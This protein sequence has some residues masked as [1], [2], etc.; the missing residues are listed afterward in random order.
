MSLSTSG[1]QKVFERITNLAYIYEVRKSS[2]FRTRTLHEAHQ[3][4]SILRL[5]P[6]SLSFRDIRAIKD[7]YGHGTTCVK[8]DMYVVAAGS[9]FSL[10]DVVDKEHHST[11]RKRLA[12]AFSA[13]NLEGWEY[14]VVDKCTRLVRQ[15]DLL[16]CQSSKDT[17]PEGAT[18]DWRLWSNLFTV[19][20]IADIALSQHLGLL[21]AGKDTVIA[22]DATGNTRQVGFIRSL[23]GIGRVAAPIVWSTKWY[24][25]LK[26]ILS[27]FKTFR[28]ELINYVAYDDIVR[29]LVS[30]R[31]SRYQKGEKLDDFFACLLEDRN[32]SPVGLA[33]GEIQAEV[34]VFMN[35]GSDT[36]AVALTHVLYY[37][38]KNPDKLDRLRRELDMV[39]DTATVVPTYTSVRNIAY[40]RA[41]L[42]EALRLSPPVSFGL[43]RK[44][45]AGGASINDFTMQKGTQA[46]QVAAGSG[47]RGPRRKTGW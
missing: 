1:I 28:T 25:F 39:L 45:L 34:N 30:R 16:C 17:G 10:L 38:L 4:N 2:G 15:F 26:K 40:L 22:Q 19:E 11:K 9:H 5:G 32:G 21:E 29:H 41:C 18:V 47:K 8:G 6:D 7:I 13:K 36:T 12:A 24:P 37:L 42:D 33:L 31:I 23:H 35:A 20:A 46:E 14:K 43:Q 44:T 27:V 3:V